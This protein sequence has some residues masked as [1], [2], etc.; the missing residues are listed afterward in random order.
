MLGS[1][2]LGR[3]EGVD[4]GLAPLAEHVAGRDP[5]A[6]LLARIAIA[7]KLPANARPTGAR[8]LDLARRVLVD[9]A[10]RPFICLPGKWLG[11]APRAVPVREP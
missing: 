8:S 7:V 6:V 3:G 5:A 10:I 9:N 11:A 2:A 4:G 1:Y